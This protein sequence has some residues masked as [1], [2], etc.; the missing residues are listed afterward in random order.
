MQRVK[1]TPPPKKKKNP[2]CC[3]YLAQH[4]FSRKVVNRQTNIQT[5]RDDKKPLPFGGGNKYFVPLQYQFIP[6]MSNFY[7]FLFI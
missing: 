1:H 3:L 2:D 5:N 6:Q 7:N 4:A